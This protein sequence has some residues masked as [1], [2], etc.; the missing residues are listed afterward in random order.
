[1]KLDTPFSFYESD[2]IVVL[3]NLVKFYLIV[4]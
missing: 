1:M 4:Q 3:T 2:L